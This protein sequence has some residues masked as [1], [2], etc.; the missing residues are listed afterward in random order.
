MINFST[1]T[2]KKKQKSTIK[3][4]KNNKKLVLESIKE[5]GTSMEFVSKQLKSDKEFM[6][7]AFK[8]NSGCLYYASEKLKNDKEFILDAQWSSLPHQ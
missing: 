2:E 5:D 6:L 3:E 8:L 1:S 4:L 7:E